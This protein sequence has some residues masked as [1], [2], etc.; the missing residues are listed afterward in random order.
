MLIA[1]ELDD[2]VEIVLIVV[3]V[4]WPGALRVTL[5]ASTLA[6]TSGSGLKMPGRFTWPGEMYG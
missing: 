1:E 5:I 4:N 3:D 6:S 2:A